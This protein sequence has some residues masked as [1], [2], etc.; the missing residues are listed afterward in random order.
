M[1]TQPPDLH[2]GPATFAIWVQATAAFEVSRGQ[3]CCRHVGCCL[4]HLLVQL[5]PAAGLGTKVATSSTY[6]CLQACK[7][8][9]TSSHLHHTAHATNPTRRPH[10]SL[11][12]RLLAPPKQCSYLLCSCA[13]SRCDLRKVIWACCP[14]SADTPPVT[15]LVPLAPGSY[16]YHTCS[17][18]G[19][20]LAGRR[21]TYTQAAWCLRKSSCPHT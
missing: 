16:P 18:A 14:A 15:G 1:Y 19:G 21:S 6:V 13:A 11:V 3:Y 9:A 5:Q 7:P 12:Q 8:S 2:P 17:R 10:A 4:C 20:T